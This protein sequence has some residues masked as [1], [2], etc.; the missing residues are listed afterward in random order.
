VKLA[1]N[2][3]WIGERELEKIVIAQDP[4]ANFIYSEH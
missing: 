3:Y 4:E 2:R 1:M